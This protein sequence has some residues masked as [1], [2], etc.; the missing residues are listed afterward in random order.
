[1]NNRKLYAA[2]ILLGTV[3][4]HGALATPTIT[5]DQHT[6]SLPASAHDLYEVGEVVRFDITASN[7]GDDASGV[8]VNYDWPGGLIFVDASSPR[9]GAVQLNVAGDQLAWHVG[10]LAGSDGLANGDTAT[11]TVRALVGAGTEGQTLTGKLSVSAMDQPAHVHSVVTSGVRVK[12]VNTV[13]LA[14]ASDN[15]FAQGGGSFNVTYNVTVTNNGPEVATGVFLQVTIDPVTFDAIE[16][17]SFTPP[18][19]V[20]CDE[21]ALSCLIGDMDPNTSVDIR[22][23]GRVLFD[24]TPI[25][26]SITLD[27][28][29]SDT[30]TD[31]NNNR[32]FASVFLPEV[33][34]DDGGGGVPGPWLLVLLA[35]ATLAS[36]RP[37][38]AD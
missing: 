27:A 3:V 17:G 9:G 32:I 13:D 19:G 12:S 31:L 7:R 28:L 35:V 14:V 33:E 2:L 37:K 16:D 30:D 15:S 10:D 1:M 5:L 6:T 11:L 24:S 23:D 4:A 20:I 29:S 38:M 25:G 21:D 36:R 18:A 34:V 26:I 8:V 22:I